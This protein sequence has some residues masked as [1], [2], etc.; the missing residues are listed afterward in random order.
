MLI[1][2][3]IVN[4]MNEAMN[5]IRYELGKEA[6]IISQRK[7]RRPGFL[8]FFKKKVIEVTAAIDN[9]NKDDK[10]MESSVEIIK[11][12]MENKEKLNSKKLELSKEEF[13]KNSHEDK[14]KQLLDK[15][16]LLNE[17]QEM[18]N[19]M[20]S[21]M[22]NSLS[23][24]QEESELEGLLKNSDLNEDIIRNI[25]MK[26]ENIDNELEDV[27]KA[28]IV[29]KE[30]IPISTMI[31]KDV[32]VLV[33][34]TG[35]GKTTTI[36]K[37]AGRLSLIEKKTVGLIT[38]D[39]YRIGA[40]EQLKTYADIMRIPFKVVFS[41]KD[42]EEA[43]SDMKDCDVILVD[44]TGRNSK[45]TMQISELRAFIDNTRTENIHL[46]IS[47]TTKNRDIDT[48]VEGYKPLGYNN[49]IITKL[50]ETTTYGSV[51]NIIQYAGKPVSFITTG[52]NVPDDIRKIDPEEMGTLILGENNIC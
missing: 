39:T 4:N 48:I 2:K 7:I 20:S 42:M 47:A 21:M 44:T 26:V 16:I 52:Q 19:M 14:N 41:I 28:K 6:I 5:R 9:S 8:G 15:E 32:I 1:K 18:K 12:I 37:L 40:V 34:P 17:I 33:G 50:D 36:A 38:I 49:I 46:V 29:I 31:L 24:S 27:E 11:K 45:N 22:N 25:L 30:M 43:I 23:V 13:N 3:Y 35:V 10:D 51:L